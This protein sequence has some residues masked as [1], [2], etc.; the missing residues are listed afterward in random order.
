MNLIAQQKNKDNNFAL[1]QY[2]SNNN[3]GGSIQNGDSIIFLL[4]T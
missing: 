2:M 4:K 1:Y 3:Y